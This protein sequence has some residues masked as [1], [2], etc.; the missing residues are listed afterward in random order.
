MGGDRR[1]WSG[2]RLGVVLPEQHHEIGRCLLETFEALGCQVQS[3]L[4]AD[5]SWPAALDLIVLY[6]PMRS[7]AGTLQRL[8][9]P[10]APSRHVAVWYTEPLPPASWPAWG[11]A[12]AADLRRGID[13]LLQGR[14]VSRRLRLLAGRL[15]CIGEMRWLQRRHLLEL[16]AVFTGRHRQLFETW[17][18]PVSVVPMG[19]HPR[20]GTLLASLLDAQRDVD[21]TFLGS[22]RDKRRR[23]IVSGLQAQFA[24]LGI[25]FALRD[26][27]P[28]HGYVFGQERVRLLNRTKIMLNLMRQPWDDPV[29]RLLLAAPNGAMVL[30]EPVLDPGPFEP[31]RHFAEAPLGEMASAVQHFLEAGEERAAIAGQ[32]HDYVTG[33]LTMEQMAC[34]FLHAWHSGQDPQRG[35]RGG[36]R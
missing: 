8:G 4:P 28:E 27:S 33:Q 31:G 3:L 15:R 17:H 14:F 1:R 2:L 5:R 6:G 22:T 11:T 9:G 30:S 24:R 32:A 36:S 25:T 13:P 21:V 35:K 12:R 20:F 19:H 7:L 10:G 18:L 29:F 23:Q 34:R 26:G 16:V